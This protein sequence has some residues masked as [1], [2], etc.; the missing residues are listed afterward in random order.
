[1]SC[2]GRAARAGPQSLA[3]SVSSVA[4]LRSIRSIDLGMA[5]SSILKC[6]S[7]LLQWDRFTISSH[8]DNDGPTDREYGRAKEQA[9]TGFRVLNRTFP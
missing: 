4:E 3:A 2:F 6:R 5:A 7:L 9:I 1:M 8:R